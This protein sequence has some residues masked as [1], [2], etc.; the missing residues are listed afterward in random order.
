MAEK[1]IVTD[2]KAKPTWRQRLFARLQALRSS[3]Q[4]TGKV[5]DG[6]RSIVIGKNIIQIGEIKVPTYLAVLAVGGI[7]ILIIIAL[8]ALP[9]LWKTG[10]D[11]EKAAAG[12]QVVIAAA[13]ATPTPTW[14]PTPIPTATRVVMPAGD[15]NI[16]VAPFMS[17]DIS[18]NPID[19]PEARERAISITRFLAT[20]NDFLAHWRFMIAKNINI[21]GPAQF[22]PM[23]APETVTEVAK[24]LGANILVYGV[25]KQLSD[26]QWELRPYFYVASLLERP[27][28]TIDEFVGPY[29]LGMSI[30]YNPLDHSDIRDLTFTLESRLRNLALM[31]VGLDYH[32]NRT[33]EGYCQAAQFF[34][35]IISNDT[36]AIRKVEQC[37]VIKSVPVDR[38]AT[39]SIDQ[40]GRT[41]A[42]L[43][44]GNTYLQL[45][46]ELNKSNQN[47][48][49]ALE[50]AKG[51]YNLGLEI[52][53]TYPRLLNGLANAL[54]FEVMT[55]DQ[56]SC[57]SLDWKQME[58]AQSLYMQSLASTTLDNLQPNSE[59]F[60]R[61]VEISSNLG[62][63][64]IYNAMYTCTPD[65]VPK[66]EMSKAYYKKVIN[67][68]QQQPNDLFVVSA[69]YAQLD[70]AYLISFY[71]KTHHANELVDFEIIKEPYQAAL[72]LSRS[73]SLPWLIKYVEQE[74][75]TCN[76]VE[77]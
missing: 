47:Y 49:I 16:A 1:P 41:L 20:E 59:I 72:T 22:I 73:S 10:N 32:E 58:Q 2:Y 28:A 71:M 57:D 42:A 19:I 5:G 66:F 53:L 68:Y 25:L 12:A 6:S 35:S 39:V 75:L 48:L 74:T 14:T 27:A 21:W 29:S 50:Q 18:N 8:S 37:A 36:L 76:F 63:G 31:F 26:T 54:Y 62:L 60:F 67:L 9:E 65:E 44:L 40:S 38:N 33:I 34:G 11:A 61:Y 13:S 30:T 15:Y 43:F 24:E 52:N 3:D 55:N 4:I 77:C 56:K 45:A 70:L 51:A 69:V 23:I 64:R 46:R 17:F 7:I